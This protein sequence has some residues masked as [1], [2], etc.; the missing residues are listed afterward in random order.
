[1]SIGNID[2]QELT[3]VALENA[4]DALFP[5]SAIATEFGGYAKEGDIV[6]VDI[7]GDS[8]GASAY[9]ASTNNYQTKNVV[10]ENFRDV[11]LNQKLLS[12]FNLTANDLKG[13]SAD[14]YRKRIQR[15]IISVMDG[16][17]KGT[18]ALVTNAN[19]GAAEV[20]GAASAF[21][22]SV[23]TQISNNAKVLKFSTMEDP[24]I[25][26]G[27]TYY[28]NLMEQP[29]IGDASQ[30]GGTDG[31]RRARMQAPYRGYEFIGSN[32]IPANGE[33]LVGFVTDGTGLCVGMGISDDHDDNGI[34]GTALARPYYTEVFEYNGMGMRLTINID[35][36]TK[37]AN[38]VIDGVYGHS[39]GQA[40]KL[41]RLTS[42]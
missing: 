24:R 14:G 8:A 21:D 39:V 17:L 16:M 29:A 40:S 34:L 36:A 9:N 31:N 33:N 37:D 5:A 22:S 26:I 18:M 15:E 32:I 19:F 38:F 11:T 23:V 13:I 10:S 42:V 41:T 35:G 27:S 12:S 7:L 20:I 4:T 2:V 28:N 30:R 6:K 25:V 3:Q 1:M